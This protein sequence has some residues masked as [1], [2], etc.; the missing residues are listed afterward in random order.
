L[1]F[2]DRKIL[3]RYSLI[4]LSLV[5]IWVIVGFLYI[6]MPLAKYFNQP[7]LEKVYYYSREITNVGYSI[8][9]FLIALCG[10]VFSNWIYPKFSGLKN[11]LSFQ[12]NISIKNWSVFS[13]KVLIVAGLFIKLLKT[14]IGR[15]RPHL[16]PEFNNLNFDILTL[17]S[18]WHSFPSGH[19]QVLF[20]VATLGYLIWP[21]QKY[22]F[23]FLASFFSLTRITIH[24]HFFSD[25]VA[26]AFIG[27]IVTLWLYNLWP[28]KIHI[29]II[30]NV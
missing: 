26:G 16:S 23:L 21:R 14:L 20:S 3:I 17:H 19:T 22:I 2:A 10:V 1:N 6:D 8:H 15:Q 30:E 28:P 27:H 11:K 29:K 13:I 18:H 5:L 25:V 7:D 9:Y 4:L 12:Q 24:Q